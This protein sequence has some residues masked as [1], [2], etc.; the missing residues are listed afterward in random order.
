MQEEN[1]ARKENKRSAG[2]VTSVKLDSTR[3]GGREDLSEIKIGGREEEREVM[4][5]V[6]TDSGNS[7][8]GGGAIIRSGKEETGR[9]TVLGGRMRR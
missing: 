6:D 2:I 9:C 4:F 5:G 8:R 7:E 1:L 3:R